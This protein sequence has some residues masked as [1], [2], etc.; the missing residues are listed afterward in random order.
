MRSIR[1]FLYGI[2]ILLIVLLV[3]AFL[4]A[5]FLSVA[6]KNEMSIGTIGE[7]STLNPIQQADSAS[8]EV[9]G[10]IFNGLLKYN[11]NLDIVGDLASDWILSQ[12]T[13]FQFATEAEAAKA[14]DY[15]NVKKSTSWDIAPQRVS[16]NWPITKGSP[17][18]KTLILT[19]SQP[20][21]QDS[22]SIL[23][24]LRQGGFHPLPFPPLTKGDP[25]RS[26]KAEPIIHFTL[27]RDV[28]WHD[29]SPF[30]SAD[31]LFTYKAIIDPRVA[32]PRS[33]DFE[34][35]SSVTNPTPYEVVVRYKKPF[36]PA[37]L[38]WMQ[39]ILPAHLLE[40]IEPAKWADFYNR[41]PIGTGPFKFDS[42]KTNEFI[43]LVKNP[44]YY[45]GS[46]W[47]DSVV[48]RV[49]PDPLT[50]RLAFE[51]HQ[52]DFWNVDPWAVKSFEHDKRFDLFSSSGNMYNYIGW[53]LRRPLFQDLRVRQALAQA[54]NIQQLIKY[55]IYGRGVQ[56]TGIF[57]PKMW[58]FDSK[59]QPL[60]FDPA[61]ARTLLD[62]AGWKPG[63]DGIRIKEGKRLSFTLLANNG[64]EIRRDIATLVQDDLKQVGVE[65][66]VEIYEWAV[67]LS[68]F[69]NKG[70]FDAIVL[71][72]GLGND[73]DQYAI[74]HSSQTHPEEL[75]FVDYQ[76]PKVDHLL[77]D[78]RQE[79][80]RPAILK[81]AAELQQT[82]YNDQ[83]YLFL[84]V[85]ESTSV[86]WKNS[87]RIR[88]PG[89]KPGEWID[90]PIT[91]SKAGWSYN[92]EW[93]YRP[94]Y[95]PGG[96]AAGVEKLKVEELKK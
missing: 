63:P 76:N 19:L 88:Q 21:L 95:P 20:G 18:G 65:V 60:T 43:R 8:S 64:N 16:P 32:S 78:L 26:F 96:K 81:M 30:T 39:A 59:V 70:E 5:T 90:S 36:S 84:F 48:F 87:Y 74:W 9:G 94:E 54:V 62:E 23:D 92:M 29:G 25:D 7:P 46:P 1:L 33:S 58:F 80:S 45:L 24:F 3:A 85:P 34:L 6:K 89:A 31:V 72:W 79:Y 37:L 17:R 40:G 13:S 93:F 91:M 22:E 73:F 11:Q 57:T 28:R 68:R 77:S 53:N 2:P 38:S 4:N 35:V 71:G 27:R 51:T 15:I 47:L 69:V 50:L 86:L 75:N 10:L 41:H 44:D 14:L 52:V 82:I 55:I 56:S 12:E 83:P 42:W 61:A 67:L 66:K 49:L